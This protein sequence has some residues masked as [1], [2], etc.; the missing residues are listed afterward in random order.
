MPFRHSARLARGRR[1]RR[2]AGAAL[3][4]AASA[5]ALG[6]TASVACRRGALQCKVLAMRFGKWLAVTAAL[7]LPP[8]AASAGRARLPQYNECFTVRTREVDTPTNTTVLRQFLAQDDLLRRSSM[9]ATGTLVHGFMQQIK[10]CDLPLGAAWFANIGGPDPTHL[11][12]K[13]MSINP[14]PADCQWTPFWEIQANASGPFKD[15]VRGLQCDRWE[16]WEAGQQFGFWGT[17]SVPLRTAKLFDPNPQHPPWYIDFLDY[18][19]GPPADAEF[20]PVLDNNCPA[21]SAPTFVEQPKSTST[22]TGLL[23]LIKMVSQV[24]AAS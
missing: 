14:A 15:T 21:A 24:N 10:R 23:R 19:S 3:A 8:T 4:A 17:D 6:A 16:W 5:A 18:Q 2:R 9:T 7:V 1:R 20:D 13:N 22:D 11:Q 12:C